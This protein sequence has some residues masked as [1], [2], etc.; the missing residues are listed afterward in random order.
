M[1]NGIKCKI[2]Y[3]NLY[4]DKLISS[5]NYENSSIL[6][7]RICIS[8]TT[9][10]MGEFLFAQE[11]FHYNDNFYEDYQNFI[12][13]KVINTSIEAEKLNY[14]DFLVIKKLIPGFLNDITELI[15]KEN[16]K[17]VGFSSSFQQTCASI[18]SMISYYP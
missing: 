8:S 16:P 13:K 12:K 6:Y 11:A 4:L 9:Y 1:E 14:R 18:G 5:I 7:K 3:A 15:L 17:I 2:I 10:L